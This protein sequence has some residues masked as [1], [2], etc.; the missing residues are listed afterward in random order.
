[1]GGIFGYAC[2]KPIDVYLVKQRVG[3]LTYRG[4]DGAGIAYDSPDKLTVIKVTGNVNFADMLKE[5]QASSD[6]ALGHTRYASRGWPSLNNT[7]PMQDCSGS[8]AVV[9]DGIIDD[10]DVIK[11]RLVREGHK[12][13]STTDAEVLPHLLEH[14]KDPLKGVLDIISSVKGMYAFAFVVHGEKKIYAASLGQ[15]IV[16]GLGDCNF[17]SSDASS[18]VGLSTKYAVLPENCAAVISADDVKAYDAHGNPVTLEFYDMKSVSPASKGGYD[19]YMLKEIHDIPSAMLSAASSLMDKYLELAGMIVH[20]AK[21]VYVIGN[22]TSLHAGLISSYYF[23]EA[24]ID[25]KVVSAAEFPYYALNN[26]EVGSVIVAISQ[27]GETSD[28]IRSVRL[29]RQRGCAIIGI[30]NTIGSRLTT[31]SSIYLPMTAGPELAV[32]ATKTFVATL[33]VLR[34]LAAHAGRQGGVIGA[35]EINEI[36]NSIVNLSRLLSQKMPDLEAEGDNVAESLYGSSGVYVTSSGINFPLAME[37][38]L[39]LKEAAL[40]HAEGIQLGELLHGPI[41]LASRGYPVVTIKPSEQEAEELY[42]KIKQAVGFRGG[43]V[44]ELS[45]AQGLMAPRDL[46]PIVNSIP[47]QFAAYKLGLKNG[48]PVDTPPGL[49]KAM[50][51]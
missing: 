39:K 37:G 29:A 31:N 35:S 16:I 1:M 36:A 41:A 3:K 21:N 42:D 11:E 15:P 33:V 38:A 5:N 22:G 30:T 40:V 24:G 7:H 46:S 45:S 2:R 48:V 50:I 27:S 23:S 34:L 4:Y 13:T 12:F 18:L 43:R 44:V 32:P 10:Y 9:M 19:H 8:I 14:Q 6:L 49:A 25:V 47:L 20:G 51:M 17:V 26:V 28:V